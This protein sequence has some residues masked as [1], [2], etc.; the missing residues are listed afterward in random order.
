VHDPLIILL[1][2]VALP[3]MFIAPV[4]WVC[5][6]VFGFKAVRNARPDINLWGRD[7]MWNPGNVLIFPDMLTDEGRH[8]RRRCFV[9]GLWFVIPTGVTIVLAVLTG[10]L[11]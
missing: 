7:T 10:N 1:A 5:I 2:L 3:T 4:A 9:A 6:L 8:Y 11:G